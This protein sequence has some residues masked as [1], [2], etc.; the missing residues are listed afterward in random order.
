MSRP[1]QI[2]LFVLGGILLG[3]LIALFLFDPAAFIEAMKQPI[4]L[5][6]DCGGCL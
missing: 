3:F 4:N 6:P 2:L 5:H 1:F